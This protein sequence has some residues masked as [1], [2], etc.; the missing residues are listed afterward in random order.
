MDVENELRIGAPAARP[1]DGHG[2]FCSFPEHLYL[3]RV[4]GYRYAANCATVP[5]GSM[6]NGIACFSDTGDADQYMTLPEKKGIT[7]K[8]IISSFDKAREIA[9]RKEGINTLILFRKGKIVDFH[10]VK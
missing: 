5:D 8:I 4:D 3:I 10:Y 7:G 2:G 6:I 1:S 9:K